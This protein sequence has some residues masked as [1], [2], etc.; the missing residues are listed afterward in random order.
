MLKKST[1][2]VCGVLMLSSKSDGVVVGSQSAGFVTTVTSDVALVLRSDGTGTGF[3]SFGLG[4]LVQ[5]NKGDG[6]HLTS[7]TPGVAL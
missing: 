7:Q 3:N 4:R 2:C 6:G 1:S 5:F